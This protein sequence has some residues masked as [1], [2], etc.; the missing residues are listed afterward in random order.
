MLEYKEL[1]EYIL[2]RP[3][4][5]LITDVDV[6]YLIN[7]VNKLNPNSLIVET[8]TFIGGTTRRMA[9][10]RPDVTIYTIDTNEYNSIEHCLW[11]DHIKKIL[12]L[13]WL[14]HTHFNDLQNIYL[15]DLPNVKRIVKKSAEF[16]S[17]KKIDLLFLDADHT[18]EYVLLE[19]KNFWDQMN[20]NGIIMGDDVN[21]QDVY[22]AIRKF[23]FEKDLEYTIYNKLYKMKKHNENNIERHNEIGTHRLKYLS[24]F[25]PLIS[26]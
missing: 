23:S 18:D 25:I 19:L 11:Y 3:I 5:S 4:I 14:D 16:V 13:D 7:E 26:K 1:K 17:D 10:A 21:H 22:N 24:E 2:N 8:G 15:E 12:N 9:L 20:Y 6:D